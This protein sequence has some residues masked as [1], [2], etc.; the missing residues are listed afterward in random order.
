MNNL[1]QSVK[2]CNLTVAIHSPKEKIE[3][4]ITVSD[5]STSVMLM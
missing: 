5:F 1:G 2:I 4:I 3:A